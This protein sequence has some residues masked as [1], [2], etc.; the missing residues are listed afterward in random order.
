MGI[1]DTPGVSLNTYKN[2][3]AD[4]INNPAINPLSRYIEPRHARLASLLNDDHISQSQSAIPA[5]IGLG[6]S[7][8]Q[9]TGASQYSNTWVWQ[10]GAKLQTYYG[11]GVI[12]NWAATNYGVGGARIDNVACYLAD[13][14]E[15]VPIRPGRIFS[16]GQYF[17]IMSIRNSAGIVSLQDYGV[18]LRA[19]IRQIKRHGLDAVMVSENPALTWAGSTYTVND[20]STNWTPWLQLAKR[21]CAEEGATFVDVW[22]YMMML[23]TQTPGSIG[24][25]LTSDGTHPNDAGHA[26]IANLAFQ[27]LISPVAPN[28]AWMDRRADVTGKSYLV[29]RYNFSTSSAPLTAISGLATNATARQVSTNEAQTNVYQFANGGTGFPQCPIPCCGIIL[30]MVNIPGST[31]QINVLYNGVSRGTFG[32]ASGPNVL[33]WSDHF[34]WLPGSS[35][36]GDV[37]SG[38]TLTATGVINLAGVVFIGRDV[39]DCQPVPSNPTPGANWTAGTMQPGAPLS[40]TSPAIQD[41]TVGDAISINWFGTSLAVQYAKGTTFGMFNYSTDG[42]AASSNVDCYL[43]AAETSAFLQ[44]AKGLTEGW[45]TTVFTIATK[46][47]SSSANTVKF[48]NFSSYCVAPMARTKYISMNAGESRTIKGSYLRAVIEQVFSGSPNVYQFVPSQPSAT[49]TLG[50][51]GSALIRLER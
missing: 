12:S 31:S 45:H 6:N 44:V 37:I 33:E 21:I 7:I 25:Y 16:L 49:L 24:Q 40:S 22:G 38:A 18:M 29:S 2:N 34:F 47:A 50:G 39:F 5:G 28:P 23:E 9:G 19:C 8:M 30:D 11:S 43:N 26:L 27:A 17:L 46:N 35:F 48:C 32:P 15:T 51:T 36:V 13:N 4:Y 41:A 14:G 1:L 20:N 10:L 3:R 42:G